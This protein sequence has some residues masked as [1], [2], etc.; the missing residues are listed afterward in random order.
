MANIDLENFAIGIDLGTTYSAVGVWRD[1]SVEIIANDQGNRTT[2]SIVA[3]NESERLIGDSAKNQQVFNMANTV[4]DAKRLIGRKFNDPEIQKD[5]PHWGFK[6]T[7]SSNNSGSGN[8]L[9]NVKYKGEDRTF[10]PEEISAMVLTKMKETAETYLGHQVKKA[11]ITVPAYFNDAQRNSTKDAARIAGLD[12]IRIINEP[13]AASI[14]Y[15]LGKLGTAE[16]TKER[17]VL[18]FDM[19]GGTFDVSILTLE[20]GLF[21]VRATAGDTH[22][23][24]EDINNRMV[25][26]FVKEF[27]RK[28]KLNDN[29]ELPKRAMGR[30]RN[31][32]ERAKR[33]LSSTNSASIEVESLYEGLDF[34]TSISR[35]KFEELCADIFKRVLEPVEQVLRD[36]KISKN[37]VHDIVLVGGST[38]IPKIQ[39][40]LSDYF[41]GKELCK[42]INPDEAVA[43]GAAVQA[44][45]LTG[46]DAQ[47]EKLGGMVL[48]DVCPLTLGI[49]TSGNIMTPLIKRNSTIPT[50][51][52]EVFS[53]YENNQTAV[54]I[55]VF[56]GERKFTKDCHLLGQF[57][58]SGIPPGPRGVPQIHV[59]YDLDAN[60]MLHVTAA[61]GE[62]DSANKKSITITN[63]KS[64]LSKEQIEKMVEEAQKF[65]EDDRQAFEKVEAR[66]ELENYVYSIKNSLGTESESTSETN[67]N[68][69]SE[70][71]KEIL[72]TC[73]ET[74]EW[75]DESRNSTES[76][77]MSVNDYKQKKEPLEKMMMEYY[78]LKQQTSGKNSSGMPEFNSETVNKEPT[79]SEVD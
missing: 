31:A 72:K 53:T 21:E 41:N 50:K 27:K 59:D 66:N 23:G 60:G 35:A 36:S 2:P 10:T 11:V 24:G 18:I 47:S 68:S 16:G 28:N 1:G 45:I 56:E 77:S 9:I 51:K 76:G 39:K 20:D 26:H 64:R 62:K 37:Q 14:A 33:S 25:E 79:I 17:N 49:E 70:K 19:G 40:L 48:L 8:P 3:F 22:L 13:T 52:S 65:A 43:Y 38:R 55:R 30:I 67:D 15:G 42:N 5:I 46:M 58:L 6:V 57:D 69:V 78:S 44:A 61:V 74:L 54:T 73:D 32:C 75:L 4:F 63:D 12:C 34:A 29:L 71:V 7:S